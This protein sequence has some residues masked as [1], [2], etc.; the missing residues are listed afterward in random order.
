MPTVSYPTYNSAG[1]SARCILRLSFNEEV[2]Q[3]TVL[4][5]LLKARI[6]MESGNYLVVDMTLG[7]N[8]V[9]SKIPG[10]F[11]RKEVKN[12]Q[13]LAY[14]EEYLELSHCGSTTP[15]PDNTIWHIDIPLLYDYFFGDYI[16]LRRFE[17]HCVKF[18]LWA[19]P[20]SSGI[21]EI[22]PE[23][24]H[25]GWWEKEYNYH[26]EP[27]LSCNRANPGLCNA[28]YIMIY[29]SSDKEDIAELTSVHCSAG[30]INIEQQV[31][32]YVGSLHL[33]L[34]IL[35]IA[36]TVKYREPWPH[37]GFYSTENNT[38]TCTFSEM[39]NDIE[40]YGLAEEEM[41]YVGGMTG[42]QYDDRVPSHLAIEVSSEN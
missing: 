29:Y 40:F 17:Y 20:K 14:A 41:A 4:K 12:I 30:H 42:R 32:H 6:Q 39:P 34:Y 1:I 22:I 21:V 23:L 25:K 9:L 5:D 33:R 16:D 13:S 35:S 3:D 11:G 8:L 2:D 26:I 10:F 19:A 7:L 38:L 31:D 15:R 24:I 28:S 27:V 18:S 36:M 37:P